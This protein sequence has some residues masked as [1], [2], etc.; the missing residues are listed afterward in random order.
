[1]ARLP[2]TVGAPP[3][4]DLRVAPGE[5]FERHHQALHRYSHAITG[6]G[7][8]AADA[9][10]RALPATAG[11]GQDTAETRNSALLKRL[12]AAKRPLGYSSTGN[13]STALLRSSALGRV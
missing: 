3:L 7:H 11:Y 1:M 8:N 13:R 5:L 12:E 9:M 6:N 4:R 2:N 10:L